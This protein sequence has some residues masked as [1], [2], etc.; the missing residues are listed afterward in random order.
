MCCAGGQEWPSTR[1]WGV[2]SWPAHPQCP[3]QPSA[4]HQA[5]A[6]RGPA[7]DRCDASG[8]AERPTAANRGAR[9]GPAGPVG[10][11]SCQQPDAGAGRGRQ[12]QLRAV[13]QRASCDRV[14]GS[15]S[16]L[17]TYCFHTGECLQYHLMRVGAW[18]AVLAAAGA[19]LLPAESW[20]KCTRSTAAVHRHTDLTLHSRLV[21]QRLMLWALPC[22]EAC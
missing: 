2:P 12:Q 17:C 13:R 20:V 11:L 18:S 15:C 14:S 4:P 21:L 22:R 8:S 6:L 9:R 7:A 3:A 16:A 1:A 5:P 19:V 10:P